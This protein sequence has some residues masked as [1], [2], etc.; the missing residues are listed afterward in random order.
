[1]IYITNLFDPDCI[2]L[3]GSLAEFV[4]TDKIEKFVNSEIVTAPTKIY[5]AKAGNYAGM[6]G[7]A[8]LA[9]EKGGK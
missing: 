1:M 7:A 4:E 3:S 8:L 6:I 2:V 9:F 5:K